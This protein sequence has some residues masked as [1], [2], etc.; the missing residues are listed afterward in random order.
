[1]DGQ[2]TDR[3]AGWGRETMG[4]GL[5]APGQ[6]IYIPAKIVFV[7]FIKTMKTNP[8]LIIFKMVGFF[9]KSMQWLLH[10]LCGVFWLVAGMTAGLSPAWA[11]A[12]YEV[13]ANTPIYFSDT[14]N[15]L[16][17][18]D[19]EGHAGLA[20]ARQHLA[21]FKPAE[22]ITHI[23]PKSHYWVVQKLVNRLGENREFIV[24]AGRTD[25]GFNWLRYQHHVVYPDGSSRE[26]NGPFSHNVPLVMGDIDPYIFTMDT[27]LSR[28]PVFTLHR[29]GEVLLFSRLKSNSTFP[30][31]SFAL[32]L[33]DRTTYLELRK[34]GL[35][36]E[37]L[38]AGLLLPLIIGTWYNLLYK[39]D[40]VS[41]VYGLW[42]V[43]GLVQV[44][45]LPIHDGQRLFEFFLSPNQGSIGVMPAHVFWFG[46]SGYVQTVLFAG[47]GS[48]FM[49]VRRHFPRFYRLTLFFVV[50]EALRFVVGYFFEHEI[51]SELFWLPSL[52]LGGIVYVGFP[53]CAVVRYRQGLRSA[54]FAAISSGI[55]FLLW[56]VSALNWLG[57][58]PFEYLPSSGL[59]L[60]LKDG[61]VW[62]A[63][64]VCVPAMITSLSIQSRARSIERRLRV[65]LQ[66][67]KEAA[68][69]QNRI[70]ES[71]VQERTREL[72]AQHRA[73][74]EA[75][76][77]VTDSVHYASRLQ[78][79]Q[80]PRAIRLENRFDSFATLW[81]PRDTIGGDLWWVSSS[82]R[83]GPYILAVADCTGHGVP[84][85]MLSLLVSNSLER[86]YAHGTHEDPATAL[87][88]LD[89]YVRTGLNQDAADSQSNDGC[90]A[91][92]LRIDRQ[93]QT[94]EFAGAKIGLFQMSREGVVTRHRVARCSLGYVERIADADRPT[95]TQLRYERGDLF[96]IVT[97][98]LTD[99]IGEMGE[100]N[101]GK[102]SYGYRR[103]AS[104]LQSH[105]G[106]DAPTVLRHLQEDFSQWQGRQAR[107]DDVTAVVFSL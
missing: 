101:R 99:Q 84:G 28:T 53:V 41:V 94:I 81:E 86:I 47:F 70:L 66:D 8:I 16:V 91:V 32:R 78:R 27:S 105:V 23:D 60:F 1:M 71:T 52:V 3:E 12:P 90:D 104:L 18:E 74:N 20:D 26:L 61:F 40:T 25:K 42:V 89:H 7:K 15:P 107:R 82:Q 44:M 92:V 103:L 6:C 64:A 69:N 48:S 37:G 80:L 29:D 19:K 88:S 75:H 83:P 39:R 10:R 21:D 38:L 34:Y 79:G 51:R 59:G 55:Y 49:G 100:N 22:S 57:M 9:A 93:Q 106:A 72:Q 13:G 63:F 87:I 102:T 24:D 14:L 95:L 31:S 45:T 17:W 35:Y 50:F 77:L 67:Q 85:A 30:A 4:C 96:V 62:L 54:Q 97:D 56:V 76:E 2:L 5:T 73:L 68:E 36:L 65:T 46:L 98:G 43:A 33:Y 58:S 11:Q